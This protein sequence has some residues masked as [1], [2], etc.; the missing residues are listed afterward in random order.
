MNNGKLEPRYRLVVDGVHTAVSYDDFEVAVRDARSQA[1]DLRVYELVDR[2]SR[3]TVWSTS[4]KSMALTRPYQILVNDK[5]RGRF[6]DARDAVRS[7]LIRK[8]ERPNDVVRIARDG[9]C[10]LEVVADDRATVLHPAA[11]RATDLRCAPADAGVALGACAS[12]DAAAP[13]AHS[14]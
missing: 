13:C 14:V 2:L 10:R 7:A 5:P 8:G 12:C 3:A 4:R 1:K 6:E 9:E 11:L